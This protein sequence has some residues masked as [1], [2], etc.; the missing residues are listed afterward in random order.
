MQ[1]AS[2]SRERSERTSPVSRE[3]SRVRRGK[4][5]AGIV[6]KISVYKVT[7]MRWR[8]WVEAVSMEE[9]D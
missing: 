5:D 1:A 7:Y 3:Q 4:A 6:V 2:A 8:A 9:K